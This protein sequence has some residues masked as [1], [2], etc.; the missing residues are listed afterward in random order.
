MARRITGR[1]RV[2]RLILALVAL[3]VVGGAGAAYALTRPG[4]A[5]VVQPVIPAGIHKIKHVVIIMQ[6]NRSFDNYFGTYPGADG[7]PMKNGVP[8]VCLP[9]PKSKQ[10]VR[11]YHDRAD[12]NLGGPHGA[13]TPRPRSTAARWT[14]SSSASS[15]GSPTY[16]PARQGAATSSIR[17][18]PAA[19]PPDV[20]GYH[21]GADL[22]NYW[23]YARNFVLQDHMFEPVSSYSLSR[24]STWSR[25]GRPCAPNRTWR[26][27]AD[28]NAQPAGG[29]RDPPGSGRQDDETPELRLDRHDLSARRAPRELEV[30]RRQRHRALL[31]Q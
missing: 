12:L 29:P 26:R 10:C 13:A 1:S 14:A 11:P 18:A 6:E 24:T 31:Q 4:P 30:L 15:A 23:A 25:P 3:I 28:N 20:M 17:H 2:T 16:I 7:I 21:T 8:T 27:A 19:V 5:R 9:N 22:P